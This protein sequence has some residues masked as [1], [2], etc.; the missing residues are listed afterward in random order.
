[1]DSGSS[2]PSATPP[3]RF[4]GKKYDLQRVQ[5]QVAKLEDSAASRRSMFRLYSTLW[6]YFLVVNGVQTRDPYQ[7]DDGGSNSQGPSPSQSHGYSGMSPTLGQRAMGLV[8][9]FNLQALE[10]IGGS[11]RPSLS[12]GMEKAVRMRGERCPLIVFRVMLLFVQE[13]DLD[14]AEQQV[15][16]FLAFLPSMLAVETDTVKN[17]LHYFL[18]YAPCPRCLPA[19]PPSDTNPACLVCLPTAGA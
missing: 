7:G 19:L 13:A 16:N 18:W 4:F 8:E 12:Q 5:R 15:H 11:A 9:S 3:R 14:L 2:T 1:M 17:R 6:D 10:L